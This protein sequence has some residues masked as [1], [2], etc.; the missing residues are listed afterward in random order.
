M[1]VTKADIVN[2]VFNKLGGTRSEA[3]DAVETVFDTMKQVLERG[4]KLLI[5]GF[6][7]FTPKDKKTRNGRNPK[8]GE[9]I[10]ISA[11]RVVTFRASPVLK[12]RMNQS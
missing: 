9:T 1:A 8:T 11:R 12:D 3:T 4:E 5:S 6:G 10:T 2:E 7:K